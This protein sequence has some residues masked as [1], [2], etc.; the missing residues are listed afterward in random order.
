M[1]INAKRITWGT[2]TRGDSA[3][4]RVT[5]GYWKELKSDEFERK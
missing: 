3:Q 2:I 1:N 5:Q 4:W